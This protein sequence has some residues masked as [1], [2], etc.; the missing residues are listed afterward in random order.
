ML[1]LKLSPIAVA[2]QTGEAK[3][4]QKRYVAVILQSRNRGH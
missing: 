2:S 1:I 4:L 3:S